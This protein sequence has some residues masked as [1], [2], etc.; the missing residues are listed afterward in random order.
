MITEKLSD[1][2]ARWIADADP[3]GPYTNEALNYMAKVVINLSSAYMI[4]GM[5]GFI[6]GRFL[7]SILAVTSFVVLRMFSGGFH[8]KSLDHCTVFSSAILAPVPFLAPYLSTSVLYIATAVSV[9]IV[10]IA[11]PKNINKSLR[12]SAKWL[13]AFKIIATLIVLTNFW[14]MSSILCLSFLLQSLLLLPSKGGET[15]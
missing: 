15:T 10:L 8:L 9:A 7:D 11:S 14:W 3:D 2:L 6:G 5:V 13:P 4:C 1:S 12:I